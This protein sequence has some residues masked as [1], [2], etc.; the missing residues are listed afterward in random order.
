MD[1]EV[2]EGVLVEQWTA[3]LLTGSCICCRG[4]VPHLTL[5]GRM[6]CSR[7]LQTTTYTGLVLL[8]CNTAVG[9]KYT[10]VFFFSS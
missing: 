10:N 3:V 8:L 9:Y 2:R 5:S 6:G 1:V 7:V 4:M